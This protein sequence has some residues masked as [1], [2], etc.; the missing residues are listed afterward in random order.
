VASKI[1]WHLLALAN[2]QR[3]LLLDEIMSGLCSADALS[4]I[5]LI[6]TLCNLFGVAVVIVV[7]QPSPAIIELFNRLL[8]LSTGR[9]IF[10]GHT[11][12]LPRYHL[13]H[14]GTESPI[15]DVETA[16]MHILEEAQRELPLL[17]CV[18]EPVIFGANSGLDARKPSSHILTT[19]PSRLWQP[20][21]VFFCLA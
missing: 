15:R 6:T 4:I 18:Y 16:L 10:S 8:L 19:S 1:G 21:D 2:Q 20:P 7:D 3:V 12:D 11:S 17:G 13:E 14:L 5:Q 9:L